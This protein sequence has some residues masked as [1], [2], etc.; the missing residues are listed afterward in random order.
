MAKALPSACSGEAM[1]FS[2][3][4]SLLLVEAMNRLRNSLLSLG[5]IESVI[6][7]TKQMSCTILPPAILI[8]WNRQDAVRHGKDGPATPVSGHYQRDVGADRIRD[9]GRDVNLMTD[10]SYKTGKK[11]TLVRA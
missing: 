6:S 1:T 8:S 5:G 2:A 7:N 3:R 9:A 10:F 11:L 4:S